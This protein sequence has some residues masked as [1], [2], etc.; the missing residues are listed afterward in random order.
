[1]TDQYLEFAKNLSLRAGEIIRTNLALGIKRVTKADQT[2]VTVVDEQINQLVLDS[3]AK[4]FPD[5]SVLAEEGSR[6]IEGSP[7]T[8]VCDPL[9]GT[10]PYTYGIPASTFVLAL[11]KDGQPIVSVVRDPFTDRTYW[12]TK[13]QKTHL[14]NLR[15]HTSSN[16]TFKNSS[17][18]MIYWQGNHQPFLVLT[19]KLIKA[20]AK[21]MV[22]A[23]IAYM[24]MMVASSELVA[25]VFPGTSPHDSAAAKL[26]IEQAGGVYTSISGEAQRYDK[27]VN[28]HLASANPEIHRQILSLLN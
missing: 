14:N 5:H 22:F 24:D 28:G 11:L 7:Y 4:S 21:V 18:G 6:L 25:T 27:K 13:T 16:T 8:W 20:G 3:I 17:V 15:I 10:I 9:D 26:I 1:M 12:A 2:P 19:N 23:S